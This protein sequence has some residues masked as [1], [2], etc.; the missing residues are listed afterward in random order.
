M[1]SSVVAV[2]LWGFPLTFAW[3]ARYG[4]STVIVLSFVTALAVYGFKVSLGGRPAFRDLLGD[5]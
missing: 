3:T 1:V 2:V 5:T 4:Y